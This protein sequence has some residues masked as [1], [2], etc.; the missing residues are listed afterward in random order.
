MIENLT[1]FNAGDGISAPDLNENFEK[2]RVQTNHNESDITYIANTALKIDGS[3]V[4]D[5]TVAQ[6]NRSL[7][8]TLPTSGVSNLSDNKEHFLAPT[9]DCTLNV[10]VIAQGDQFSHTINI[11]V[12]GSNNGVTLMENGTPITR[13]LLNGENVDTTLPYNL[14]LLYNHL[15][16][17]WYFYISQ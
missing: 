9:G 12:Q 6:F 1:I 8:V 4:T 14:L 15:D 2:L 17:H 5:E 11:A 16:G 10:P 7:T 3:N 13:H